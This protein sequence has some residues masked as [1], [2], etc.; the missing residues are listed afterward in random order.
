MAVKIPKRERSGL[1]ADTKFRQHLDQRLGGLSVDRYSWW[2]HWQELAQYIIPRRYKWLITPNQA[3]RGS[4]INQRIV[5]GTG[6]IALRTLT[7]GFSGGMTNPTSTWF[8]L[9]LDDTELAEF[10]SVKVWLSE[11]TRRILTVFAV[12]NFYESIGTLYEDLGAFGTG[13]MLIYEDFD[14]VIRCYNSCAG[15]YYL[16]NS[17]RMAVDTMYRLFVL[18]TGQTAKRFG[19]DRCSDTIK[20][21][22][23][24]AGAGLARE[25]AIAHAVE[26][27]DNDFSEMPGLRGK[28]YREAYWE[29]GSSQKT[30]LRVRG[31]N[32]NPVIAV[33]W[34]AYAND[35]YGRG[36][37][38]DALGDIKQLQVMT[39]RE[40]QAI[41]KMV[42][43][44][45]GADVQLK[46]EPAS[47]LPGG[48]TY[49][50][51]GASQKPQFYP[52]YKVEPDLEKFGKSKQEV[53]Q[54]IK[55]AF[56]TDIFM[57]WANMEGVQ[58]RNELEIMKREGE[59]MI[60]LGPVITRFANEALAP[61]IFRTYNIMAR[62]GLLPPQPPELR[63]QRIK[64]EFVS[65]L[66]QA[67]KAAMTTGME[68]FAT[69]VGRIFATQ[70][71]VADNVDF[72]E[73]VQLY[74]EHTGVDPRVL[75]PFADVMKARAA[76]AKQQ[77]AATAMQATMAGVQGAKVL[78]ETDVGGGKNALESMA[79]G[80]Q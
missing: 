4:P 39:K 1:D 44:P 46:N 52:L 80:A 42:N 64:P 76:R 13:V 27:N 77:Q 72:D 8:Q 26:P 18:T 9:T 58:P 7:N 28:L 36:P 49:M 73:M 78:S 12:S 10:Y 5:D 47:L 70:P 50:S 61:A 16:A 29:W 3:S 15:E 35:A 6:T 25:V 41:D 63:G 33:R 79:G 56:F 48:V 66:A 30:L 38:M 32:E 69:F 17:P 14:D 19:L 11:V 71:D 45:M 43:P 54:R 24:Q 65:V 68:Q 34:S 21:A 22:V 53:Q 31:F 20:Q 67:Q 60:Q 37:G 59:R 55:V 40:A 51:M 74:G 23:A 2:V 75:K 62:A 57:M